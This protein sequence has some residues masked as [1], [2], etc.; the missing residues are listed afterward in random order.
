[1]KIF[2]SGLPD[3]L[4]DLR[5]ALFR[6]LSVDEIKIDKRTESRATSE[7]MLLEMGQLIDIKICFREVVCAGSLP[8]RQGSIPNL[9]E[10]WEIMNAFVEQSMVDLEIVKRFFQ[11][12]IVHGAGT[13]FNI[14]PGKKDLIDLFCV[15]SDQYIVVCKF[16]G[17][18]NGIERAYHDPFEW[19]IGDPCPVEIRKQL[20]P[21]F[22]IA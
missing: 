21:F 12:D 8:D 6:N 15:P 10:D 16:A 2:E 14:A 19:D 13:I 22:G 3:C 20:F 4:I 17:V 9:F 1:M 18:R 7:I 11:I 5:P